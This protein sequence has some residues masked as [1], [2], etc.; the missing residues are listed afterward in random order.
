MGSTLIVGG[1]IAGLASA[2]HLAHAGVHDVMVL[3]REPRLGLHA[4]AQNAAILRTASPS[5]AT[6]ELGRESLA[7]LENP[8]PGFSSARLLEACGLVLVAGAETP[9]LVRRL[10][11]GDAHAIRAEEVLRRA[12]HLRAS[13][14]TDPAGGPERAAFWF[15]REGRVDVP[16]LLAAFA[17][18]AQQ[19]GVHVRTSARVRALLP[20]ARGVELE[21]GERIP[22]ER[23]VLAA[24]AWAGELGRSV[25]SR[26]KL[27]SSRRHVLQSAPDPGIA[28]HA[29]IVWFE[30]RGYYARPESGGVLQ[31]AC[32]ET[33]CAPDRLHVDE[34]EL[35]RIRAA[36]E[37]HL[38]DA[39][40]L[41]SA[42]FWAGLR[43][44]EPSGE[45]VLGSDPDVPRLVWAAGLGGHGVTCAPAVGRRVA[46][47]V[48]EDRGATSR[49]AIQ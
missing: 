17:S 33:P 41:R 23:V 43:T 15:P 32:D 39:R 2:W 46:E 21:D 9:W 38:I 6:E 35:Q 14:L 19:L 7:F 28:A 8:P 22:A 4:T 11:Q 5:R 49:H 27:A 45:F 25:G 30:D 47:L 26:V 36:S 40:E 20:E 42:R 10:D 29:P 12:P 18:G 3:E 34:H 16:A 48:L 31:C 1:G 44:F 24:G 37:L 13:A